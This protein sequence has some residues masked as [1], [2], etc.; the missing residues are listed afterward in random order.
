MMAM[1]NQKRQQDKTFLELKVD[2]CHDK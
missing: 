1:V 2:I